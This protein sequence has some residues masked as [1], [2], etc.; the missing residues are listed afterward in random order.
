LETQLLIDLE[1]LAG[2]QN[3]SFYANT[4]AIYNDGRIRRDLA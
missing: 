4:F 2:W 3:W 1:K